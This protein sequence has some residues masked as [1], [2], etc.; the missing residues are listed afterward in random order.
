MKSIWYYC[1]ACKKKLRR[2]KAEVALAGGKSFC[3][4]TGKDVKIRPAEESK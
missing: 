4:K 3:L 1:P 2:T